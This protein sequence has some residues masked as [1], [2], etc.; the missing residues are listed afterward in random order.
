MRVIS[1]KLLNEL[2]RRYPEAKAELDAWFHEVEAAIWAN[3]AQI[4]EQYGSASILKSSRVV[5]NICGNKYRLVTKVNY[6]Y[7]IV[8][9]RFAGTH[10]E[11]D[12]I[13]AE[14]I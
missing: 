2:A 8:Y 12:H 10:R 13:D 7:S 3:P 6:P 11:Y 14:A 1:R 5:F 9:V 4:K